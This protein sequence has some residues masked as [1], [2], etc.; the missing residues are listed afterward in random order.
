MMK[1]LSL[2]QFWKTLTKIHLS[3]SL[4]LLEVKSQMMYI[5]ALS[6]HNA[7]NWI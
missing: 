7:I 2:Q 1:F 4:L 6:L 5:H 3:T